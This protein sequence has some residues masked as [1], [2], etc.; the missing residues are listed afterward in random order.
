MNDEEKKKKCNKRNIL[1]DN[2]CG[3]DIPKGWSVL[4][5]SKVRA[6]VK[7]NIFLLTGIV[8][9]KRF[10]KVKEERVTDQT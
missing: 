6:K 2:N 1:I 3:K 4:T 8:E 10:K 7:V 5:R 9:M